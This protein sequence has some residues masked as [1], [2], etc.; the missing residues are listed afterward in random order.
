MANPIIVAGGARAYTNALY[1][2]IDSGVVSADDLLNDLLCYL[3]EHEVEDFVIRNLRLRD[4]D[5]E[6][7][8]RHEDE[9]E[10]EEETA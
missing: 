10:Q 4:D 6:C 8:I 3:S 9:L 5:N 1:E 2:L 7:V